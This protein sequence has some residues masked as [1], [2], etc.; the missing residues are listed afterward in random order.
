MAH[1][2]L[3]SL[4]ILHG[5]VTLPRQGVWHAEL[6]LE[7][8]A[9]PTG[10]AV[11]RV[12][13]ALRLR[14]VVERSG[15]FAGQV[16][17]RVVGGA[18]GLGTE[19][20]PRW[21]EG[22]PRELPLRDLVEE[23]GERLSS[24]C[25]PGLLGEVLT[26]GWTRL[27]GTAAAALAR[28]LEGTG[29][30]WRLLPDG[31]LWAGPE[32][33]PTAQ[34]MA[35]L[36]VLEEDR[37]RGRL[38]LATEAP[39][40]LPGQTLRGDRISDVEITI[41]PEQLRVEALLERATP[42]VGDRFKGALLALVEGLVRRRTDYLGKYPGIVVALVAGGRVEI[43]MDDRQRWPDPTVVELRQG[44]GEE[45]TVELGCRV[46]LEFEG[47]DPRKPICRPWDQ[48]GLKEKRTTATDK[49]SFNAAQT[50]FNDGTREVALKGDMVTSGGLTTLVQFV[51]VGTLPGSAPPAPMQLNVP[52]QVYWMA[53]DALGGP[54]IPLPFLPGQII[55]GDP[56]VKGGG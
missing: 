39:Q 36:V 27:R 22:A 14:G 19:L 51:P 34:G 44:A 9:P 55:S 33:W 1:S 17:A 54:P 47:G 29:A 3:N 24:S 53:V 26:P 43:R 37:A 8:A 5:T 12:G 42:G 56:K 48:G 6:V 28:L 13:A 23:A 31:S 18:G 49:V 16:R 15:I 7:A 45:V 30:S 11:L 25:D 40:L 20:P 2:D 4:P 32:T 21:Y 50:V 10:T 41:E 46:Q 52:Y 38:V 35:D